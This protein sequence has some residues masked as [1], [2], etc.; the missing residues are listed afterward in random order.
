MLGVVIS[1]PSGALISINLGTFAKP[2]SVLSPNAFATES[3]WDPFI[4]SVDLSEISPLA[5]FVTFMLVSTSF[6]VAS[7]VVNGIA[8]ITTSLGLIW[9]SAVSSFP[10]LTIFLPVVVSF[11]T[12]F[13]SK[14]PFPSTY[15]L[16]LM[17]LS[18]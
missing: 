4:A 12:S 13:L 5:T 3:N 8:F 14:Y 18:L 2:F 10:A 1:L 15:T 17:S 16:S 11:S 6:P 7:F 9:V